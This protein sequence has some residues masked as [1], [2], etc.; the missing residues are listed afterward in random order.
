V[1]SLADLIKLRDAVASEA[2]AFLEV[3][4]RS[5]HPV[6]GY[7]ALHDVDA[8]DGGS[9]TRL[10]LRGDHVE[11]VYVG[12]AGLPPGTDH[13][14]LVALARSEGAKLPSRQGK[15]ASMHVV[16]PE[17]MAWSELDGEVGWLELFQPRTLE[18]YLD[19]IYARPPVFRQ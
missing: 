9:G 11:L 10:F 13:Q 18:R 17:G 6:S 5:R 3:D 14:A 7:G 12:G 15:L 4:L 8:L 19:E 2:A 16:A 1:T